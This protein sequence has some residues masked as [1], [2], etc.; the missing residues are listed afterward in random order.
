M[1]PGWDDGHNK[2]GDKEGEG[3]IPY[4][5]THATHCSHEVLTGNDLDDG[6]NKEGDARPLGRHAHEE[7]P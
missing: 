4:C 6:C 7:H 3:D 5:A 2:E 1:M